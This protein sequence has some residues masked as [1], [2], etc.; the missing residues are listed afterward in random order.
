MA[1]V[2]QSLS[3]PQA[4]ALV[5]AATVRARRDLTR[6]KSAGIA[7]YRTP[8]GSEDFGAPSFVVRHLRATT[9]PTVRLLF[10]VVVD[11]VAVI[12]VMGVIFVSRIFFGAGNRRV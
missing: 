7:F 5:S 4:A 8:R 6:S 9:A 3:T 12:V 2:H 1:Y 10:V 11:V